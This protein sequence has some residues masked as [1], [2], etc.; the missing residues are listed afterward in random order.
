VRGALFNAIDAFE[1]AP[2]T[3]GGND[4]ICEC[5]FGALIGRSDPLPSE[6]P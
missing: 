4:W 5:E 6:L 1:A 3:A 2:S